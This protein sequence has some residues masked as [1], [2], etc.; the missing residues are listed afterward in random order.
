M[1]AIHKMEDFARAVTQIKHSAKAAFGKDE[2]YL[3]KLVNRAPLRPDRC[4]GPFGN[5][6]SGRRQM[7]NRR[8]SSCLS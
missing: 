5:L 4:E 3:E 2:V 7:I 8:I 6:R 1:R